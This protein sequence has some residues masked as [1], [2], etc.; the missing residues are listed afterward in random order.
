MNEQ[1]SLFSEPPP[2]E[3][4]DTLTLAHFAERAYL[5][6]AISVVKGRA[7]P[8]V[9][10]GQ[11][12]VQRRILFSMNE[13]G[14]NAAAK[15][16]KSATVVG[17]VLGKL[18][19]HG[20]QSV[21]D[22]MV[23][24]AQDFSLRYPLIDGQGNFG[25]RDGDG[26]AAMRYTEARLTPISKLLLDEI[27]M[28]TVD[29]QPNYDGS[30]EEPKLL[31]AR[32]PFVLLNGASGIA[33]GLATE[34]PSH[35]LNEVAKAAVAMIRN[36]KI[37]HA[38][39]MEIIP[40]PDFPGG[41]QIITAPS[42]VS[43]MY[44]NGRG[45]VKVRARWKIE[46]MARGQWQAVVTEL[47]PGA[48]SQ[49]VLEEIEELTNP[50]VKLGKKAL[51]PEQLA[52]KQSMLAS[53]DT[54]RDES[55]RDAPI[56]LV[57][58]PKS[59]NIDQTEFMN[60]LLAHT[61]L[62]S[63]ASLNLV[64]IGGDGRPRQKGLSA[65][66]QEWIEFRFTT[67]TRRT[68]HRLQQV[69]DR[70]H[71]LEGREAVLLNIDKVIKIIRE[72]DEPKPALMQ[73]FRLSDRQAE[74]IL[75]IRLRQLARLEAI[76]IQQQLL[77]LRSEQ[78]GLQD[79]LDN[80]TS[81]KRLIIKEI[82][83]DAKQYGDARRTLIEE[84]EKAVI[85]QKVIDEPVTVIISQKGWL[86][87]RTGHAHDAAQF[88]FKAG[89]AL[90]GAFECRTVDTLLAFGSNGR[91]YSVPVSALP[92]ARGDGAP[93]TTLVELASGTR[94]L[95]YYA[96]PADVTML[97]ASTAGYG[98]TAK[99]ADMVSRLKAGKAFMTLE[100]GDEPLIPRPLPED[101]SAIACLS[102]KGKLL[103]FGLDE[104]KNL[105]GGGRGVIL[106]D[107]E[108]GEKLLGALAITK[109][110][111]VVVG[112]GRGG[113]LQEVP[114]SASGLAEHIGKRARKGKALESKIKPLGLTYPA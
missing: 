18:H 78:E 10:D 12:P 25:S 73:A 36:P 80:P 22:A 92:N 96:G 28:G 87:A 76:K 37:S 13:L 26:A 2:P 58:E 35:N 63:S 17:D 107:L 15:P 1:A 5:D 55:G 97:M 112:T 100:E 47:P 71:I 29:F 16:R 93:I 8:D 6:Y 72:S 59:K 81:M 11:K 65:I 20:D 109:R 84:A 66:L 54:V 33:V 104:I 39:L 31:P 98:F 74:D 88:T 94:I 82:E 34:I 45:S 30:T 57:F 61:S 56:R 89:D 70:I 90:Y 27:G 102:E 46:D 24:M 49:K 68:Q 51:T 110:G 14:L 77:E 41:G 7:L 64:M 99:A 108:Q 79:L 21:Y 85:E 40:G 67:V 48:S 101:A 4:G 62:E 43:E 113:K 103:V 95:H 50:K 52:L 38:E 42:A 105:S 91:V 23:R 44:E 60:M 114:L 53:L 69:L 3:G 106:M 75:E 9:C 19:P 111:V 86:R 32:L 83:G